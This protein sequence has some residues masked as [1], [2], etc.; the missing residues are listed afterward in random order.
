MQPQRHF[1]ALLIWIVFA[2][3]SNGAAATTQLPTA[4]RPTHYD[5]AIEPDAKALTF[6]AQV[7]IR[8]DVLQPTASITLN[9]LD[10]S[11]TAA[12]LSGAATGKVFATPGIK[13]DA[14][15]QTA[16][17]DFGQVI[18]VGSYQLALEYTGKISTQS[19]GMFAVDYDTAAGRKRAIYTQFEAADARR[20]VPSWDEPAYKA[21][22]SLQATVPAEQMAVSNM[23]PARELDA[24]GGRRRVEFQTT[25][26]MS[27][28]L[29]FFA[30]GD[31]ER[32][33][34][35]IDGTEHGIVTQKGALPQAAF[36]LESSVRILREF[37][38]YFGTPYPLPK[39]DNIAVPGSSQFFGAMENWGA[40]LTFEQYLLLDPAISTQADKQ[41]A[42][43]TQAHEMAH[44]WFGNLVTMRWWDDLW[45]NEGF[46][47]WLGD[48][49]TA[50]LHPEWNTALEAVGS[51]E[52][53]MRLDALKTTH[54]VVQRVDTVDQA[55]QAFDAITYLKGQAVIRML[56]AY[57]GADAWRAGVRRYIKSHSYGNTS[58]Q[59]LWR[60]IE[61][62]SGQPIMA[63]AR[64]F[65]LQ[66]GVPLIRVGDAVCTAG[67]SRLKLTQAEFSRDQPDKN[68]LRWRVPV[69]VKSLDSNANVR[70]LVSGGSASIDIQG[71]GPVIVNAGQDG[72]Y[73]TLYPPRQFAAVAQSFASIGPVD[74]LG[75]LADSW[76]LGRAG[77]QPVTDALLLAEKT[78]PGADPKVWS[79]VAGIFADINNYYR[80]K[81]ERQ[82]RFQRFAIAKLTPVLARVGW[83]AKPGEQDAVAIL[84]EELIRTLS[85]LGDPVVISEARRRYGL[86]S[87]DPTA[88]PA[89]L[90]RTI[91]AVVARHADAATWDQLHTA[92]RAEQSAVIKRELYSLLAQ[93]SDP[94]LVKKALALAMTDEPGAMTSPEMVAAASNLNP[95]LA[96]DF[97][98]ANYAAV[99]KFVDATSQTEYFAQLAYA[100]VDPAMIDK[101]KAYAVAKL[102]E[103]SRR[104]ADTAV[105]AIADRI[106]VRRKQ[107][108][109]IDAWLT[110]GG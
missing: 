32:L 15:N 87:S 95:D 68:S 11:I 47:S 43:A 75:L 20:F 27:S 3:T 62:A 104:V 49:T 55:N 13:I 60:A 70:K 34:N 28:Y 56:E 73:R 48:R 44:Q 83:L 92:A 6:S 16:T 45:L 109:A 81:R 31:F 50:R 100:S 36:A 33:A 23:P 14:S 96:F 103:G 1:F 26:R 66:P 67:R 82:A 91:L 12:R 71:C 106:E 102:A 58:S 101:V 94:G 21:T 9:A 7:S 84:R 4:V 77:Y 25:P 10:L 5:V 88:V 74:Q 63:I 38:D 22:F 37:N 108:P 51:R 24:G 59:D 99:M 105:A 79:Q 76:S 54:P 89:A 17:F 69:V 18:P 46:A 53:A 65:T 40:I 2:T 90:R 35:K 72:Y 86:Q 30:V 8:I 110:K 64:D 85:A 93:A 52:A 39:L 57:V 78:P 19:S 107:L 80:G 42:F 98:M 41:G 61:T 97:A 29:L